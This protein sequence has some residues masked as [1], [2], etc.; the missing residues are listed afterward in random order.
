MKEVV[1]LIRCDACMK[2]IH[3]SSDPEIAKD[4]IPDDWS[5]ETE[6]GDL[7][8]ACTRAWENYKK[9]FIEKMRINVKEDLV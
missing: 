6:I 4:E 3:V 1:K 8:P 2:E 7:C 5:F 9:S